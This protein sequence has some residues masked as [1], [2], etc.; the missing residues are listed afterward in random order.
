MPVLGVQELRAPSYLTCLLLYPIKTVPYLMLIEY[1]QWE[2]EAGG[3]G[4]SQARVRAAR[5]EW[6]MDLGLWFC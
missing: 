1:P 2:T 3:S 5:Q 6:S 4:G